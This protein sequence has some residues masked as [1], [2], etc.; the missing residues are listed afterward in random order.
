MFVVPNM[1]NT[2][3]GNYDHVIANN[4]IIDIYMRELYFGNKKK[5]EGHFIRLLYLV[6]P[7]QYTVFQNV[8][9]FYQGK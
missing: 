8:I 1:Y 3:C 4:V 6:S 5:Y 2:I 7:K 9:I